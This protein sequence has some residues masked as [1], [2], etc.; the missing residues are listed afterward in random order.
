MER[1]AFSVDINR[2]EAE[3]ESLRMIRQ[4]VSDCRGDVARVMRNQNMS[5]MIGIKMALLKISV[6]MKSE[7]R[8]LAAL[9]DTLGEAVSL[10][11]AAER[12]LSEVK[13]AKENPAFDDVGSY[14]GNQGAPVKN[15]KS[16]SSK[17]DLLNEIVR[18]YHPDYTDKEVEKLLSELNMEGCGYVALINTLFV[19]YLGREDRFMEVFGFPMY[20][21]NGELNYDALVTDLY[22][23]KD[24]PNMSGTTRA[25]REPIWESYLKEHNITV[26]VKNVNVTA[27]NFEE[28]S[29]GGQIIVGLGPCIL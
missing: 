12:N 24:D 22:C 7:M 18:K 28:L 4:R 19:Q 26:D 13:N 10:Y 8:I 15:Y 17:R 14:G 25:S 21:N 6:Q 5:F 27:E 23:S 9:D 3:R 2:A 11:G 20:D 1:T 16:D 29:K